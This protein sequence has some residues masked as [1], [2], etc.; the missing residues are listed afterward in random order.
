MT[1]NRIAAIICIA[2]GLCAIV[3]S[4]RRPVTAP[5]P[6][7][8]W[9]PLPQ[10]SSSDGPRF[11]LLP[12]K[13]TGV[14]FENTLLPEH[15]IRH[16]F[17]G[18]GVTSGDIDGD[19]LPDVYLV[20][21]DG[22]NKLYRQTSPWQFEDITESA[23]VDGG[24]A[25]GTG[26]TL[27]DV[28]NDGDL[29][30]YVCNLD[31][32]DLLYINRGDGTFSEE[33]EERGVNH[34][35]PSIMA[36]FADYDRDG[37]LDFYLLTYRTLAYQLEF[38]ELSRILAS[39]DAIP[40]KYRDD[41][42]REEGGGIVE[43]G[44]P[45]VLF[46]N[47]GS[48]F[49]T[50]VS[51]SAGVHAGLDLGL[52]AVW[53]DYNDDGWPDIYVGND[54]NGPD[55]LYHNNG[56]GTFTN[57]IQD[58]VPYTPWFSM[59]S[60]FGD[61]NNDGSFDFV[62][63]D[64]NGTT[65][66][67]QKVQMGDISRSRWFLSNAVPRQ[68]MRNVVYL[69]SGS[70]PFFEVGYLSGLAASDWTWAIRIA[71]FDNDGREDVFF[72]NGMA[73]D[74]RDSDMIDL[75]RRMRAAHGE[76]AGE[77]LR[78]IGLN[79]ADR[80]PLRQKNLAFR[81]LGN[82][83][84]ADT[85]AEWGLDLKGVSYGVT[86]SDFDGDGDLDMIINNMNEPAAV[87]RND[88]T[89]T[90]RVVIKL[91]GRQSNRFGIGSRVTLTTRGGQQVRLLTAARGY[92]GSDV[93]AV[94]FGLGDAE[95]IDRLA[96]EWPSGIRQ[97]LSSLPGDRV[98][99]IREPPEDSSLSP[100]SPPGKRL[101]PTSQFSEPAGRIGL[102][103]Q[104]RELPYDDFEGQ[105]LLP[106][107]LS[108][109]GPGLA[110]GDVDNDGDDDLFVGGGSGQSPEL[111]VLGGDGQFRRAENSPWQQQDT[112]DGAHEDMGGLWLDFDTD[113]DLD[114]YVV[115]GGVEG[116]YQ[117]RLYVND[118]SG[119]LSLSPGAVPEM[120]SSGSCVVA[121][122]VD[123]DGDVDLFVGGRVVPGAYPVI[124]DSHLLINHNGRFVDETVNLAHG[125]QGV[126]M[127]T[128]AIWSDMD[129]DGWCDLLVT[130]EWGPVKVF[131]NDHGR[132]VDST[133]ISGLNSHLGWWNGIAGGD[134][135]NDGDID[136]VVTNF[137]LN[138]KY[139]ATAEKPR[140][141]YYHDFDGNGVH[142][143]IEAKF[144]GQR[145]LPERGRSCSALAMPDIATR[146]PSYR[147]Y[148]G[149]SLQELYGDSALDR[150]LT[151]EV[152]R[153]DVSVLINDG[154]GRFDVQSL[155][156]LAQI[157]PSFGVVLE[158]FN[159][160]GN[161]DILLAQNFYPNQVETGLMNMGLGLYL[162]GNGDG[163]FEP[164]WPARSGVV[165]RDDCRSLVAADL[166]ADGW[167]DAVVGVNSGP[168]RVLMNQGADDRSTLTVIL[169]GPNGNP[170]GVGCRAALRMASGRTQYREVYAGSGYLSQ[171][172]PRL[173]FGFPKHDRVKDLVVH[174]PDGSEQNV[175]LAGRE[176]IV[177]VEHSLDL[178]VR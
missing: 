96:I 133:V 156:R 35:G 91:E 168:V 158:D 10:Q 122:D 12:G 100:V 152:N 58:V 85:S 139:K 3:V 97:D 34:A 172:S 99:T 145:L 94:H 80:P 153:L 76:L 67:R 13:E 27:V 77:H 46:E 29:D 161:L 21:Q 71:D 54:Y 89:G 141:M 24:N 117:D 56:D 26:P 165:V 68:Y 113:G 66:F 93:P 98:Y 69:N 112:D 50:D 82:L 162:E 104:H 105:S 74:A 53:W 5:L 31:K 177:E 45:D 9:E 150:A 137:G 129:N 87:Y 173:V 135:D 18:A 11:R 63:G 101:S 33:G 38:P 86:T 128:G 70:G 127:V 109:F 174:W 41:V 28:D 61:L 90:H 64:M 78:Q 52:S 170:T 121:G 16:Y 154:S 125:L 72:A 19:G 36:A 157:S 111:Y 51:R 176:R 62:I 103:F 79:N 131:R 57:V 136:F 175:A 4:C 142:E 115:S 123:H 6:E 95:T 40:E 30:L 132:L 47:D 114:L 88:S 143:I 39:G 75:A 160:D 120:E 144:E 119:M 42:R 23:G 43:L 65:H 92:Q 81:N 149:C 106:Y 166:N 55:Y 147:A 83:V 171:S 148:A 8:R 107:R 126:G 134:V 155:P 130:L 146:F 116:H 138:T 110:I 48:G 1:Y 140:R 84:F 25:I 15:R 151:F 178:P 159:A 73:N 164:V 163:G 59:G 49:F 118:G 108:R 22:R 32:P 102:D 44:R 60:D 7:L 20:S 124:P 169:R 14:E 2:T 167:V 37:D 17:V